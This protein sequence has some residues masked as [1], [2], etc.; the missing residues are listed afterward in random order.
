MG[1]KLPG[2]MDVDKPWL[3][4]LDASKEQRGPFTLDQ[5]R[6]MRASGFLL[7]AA[8]V[9]TEGMEEWRV[10]GEFPDLLKEI[11]ED[12]QAAAAKKQA[13]AEVQ[14]YLMTN[15]F[16]KDKDDKLRGPFTLDQLK[17]QWSEG[18]L[19]GLS[20]VRCDERE[21]TAV[22][23]WPELKILFQ[24]L[25]SRKAQAEPEKLLSPEE[26]AKAEEKKRQKQEKRLRK[27]LQ[28]QGKVWTNYKKNTNLFVEGLPSDVTEKELI[29]VFGQFGV[30]KEADDKKPKV[31]VYR[32]PEGFVKGEG[33][34]SY[35]F[36]ESVENAI[37]VLDQTPLRLGDSL[38]M[39]LSH[40]VFQPKGPEF[41]PRETKSKDKKKENKIKKQQML[42]WADGADVGVNGR[43]IIIHNM[44]DPVE[45]D[46]PDRV[47]EI[48]TFR[49]EVEEECLKFGEVEKIH[50]FDR[51]PKGVIAV[52]FKEQEAAET[53]LSVMN[54]R[55]FAKRQLTA[56]FYDGKTDY[57][58]AA[59]Q[60]H[61]HA[62]DEDK[63][64][65]EF[66]QWIENKADS[67]DES[68]DDDDDDDNSNHN[69]SAAT[70]VPPKAEERAHKRNKLEK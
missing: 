7:D 26:Q 62:N 27:K 54:G 65:S 50:I 31:K 60:Q 25:Y 16:Y 41:V 3:C 24:S 29:E 42:S 21:W 8:I 58:G 64:L 45:F 23:D 18:N 39:K 53:C 47:G 61:Q 20:A 51:N 43:M 57:R 66:E 14:L 70:H 56:E 13:I 22:S 15:W 34:I 9:W 33:L 46:V 36:E 69:H 37:K 59:A 55:W 12:P 2:D 4:I 28:K 40:A 1:K 52:R 11:G 6:E 5:L 32:T 35:M 49:S 44:F 68:D 30:I 67:D 19:D 48:E 10:V 17:V 63:R 38:R